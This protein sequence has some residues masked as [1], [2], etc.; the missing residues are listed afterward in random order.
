MNAEMCGLISVE[1]P[2]SRE[3]GGGEG[4]GGIFVTLRHFNRKSFGT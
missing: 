4:G 3:G 1:R 2:C